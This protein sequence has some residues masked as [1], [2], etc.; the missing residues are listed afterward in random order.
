M[1]LPPLQP[2]PC[3]LELP[4]AAAE[5]AG[6]LVLARRSD[7]GPLVAVGGAGVRLR[8]VPDQSH[9]A[10]AV[11][12]FLSL[13]PLFLLLA[14]ANGLLAHALGPVARVVALLFLFAWV[15]L[16]PGLTDGL[17]SQELAEGRWLL[18]GSWWRGQLLP[19]ALCLLLAAAGLL[20][21]AVRSSRRRPR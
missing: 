4:L 2:G 15:L 3:R 20:A 10:N 7:Q 9:A 13:L 21:E 5:V 16:A 1:A 19:C 6:P 18:D 17:K 8:L 14:L 12:A 11:L